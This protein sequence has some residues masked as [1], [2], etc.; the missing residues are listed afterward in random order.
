M[1]PQP[2][3]RI[4]DAEREAAVHALGEHFA[5]GRLTKD[6]YDERS[7]QA[8]TARTRSQLDPLFAD[9]PRPQAPRPD[10]ARGWT[11]P[12]GRRPGWWGRGW[13]VPVLVIVVALTVLTHLPLLLLVL[14]ACLLFARGSR[15]WGPPG[16]PGW[17]RRDRFR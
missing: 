17:G 7:G 13:V 11:T 10:A 14:V 4:G 9:L 3:T 2:E 16:P 6:E 5:A 1:S 15:R 12:P 8:W